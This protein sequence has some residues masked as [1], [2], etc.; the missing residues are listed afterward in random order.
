MNEEFYMVSFE[1]SGNFYFFHN[2]E[3]ACTF[4]LDSYFDDNEVETE[5]ECVIINNE[6]ADYGGINGYGWVDKV[7]FEK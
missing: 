1:A 7:Y 4:L 6:I 5:D 2:H 3:D